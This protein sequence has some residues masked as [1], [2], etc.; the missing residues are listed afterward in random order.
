MESIPTVGRIQMNSDLQALLQT[1]QQQLQS[2]MF[3]LK[4]HAFVVYGCLVCCAVF[5]MLSFWKLCQIYN[6]LR[7]P[8]RP[9][10]HSSPSSA[11][12]IDQ[13]RVAFDSAMKGESRYLS[14]P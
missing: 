14:K 10:L 11:P 6:A 12:S 3:W 5:S 8:F 1:Q 4:V 9:Q 7:V 2:A 13:L